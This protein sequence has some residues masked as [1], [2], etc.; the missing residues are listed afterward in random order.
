MMPDG[1]PVSYNPSV[2]ALL[3]PF[4]AALACGITLS[5]E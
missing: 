3:M 5:S 2:P 1:H 4:D